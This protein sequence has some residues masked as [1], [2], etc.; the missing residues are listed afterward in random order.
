MRP[1]PTA[2]KSP[3]KKSAKSVTKKPATAKKAAPPPR[4]TK[5]GVAKKPIA[6]KPVVKKPV[7]KKPVPKKAGVA[8]PK[9]TRVAST[10]PA[11][12]ST[13]PALP[14][15]TKSAKTSTAKRSLLDRLAT[16]TIP[17]D[18]WALSRVQPGQG[19]TPHIDQLFAIG[20]PSM[21]TVVDEPLV[22]T[23]PDKALKTYDLSRV[24]SLEMLPRL[25]ALKSAYGEDEARLAFAREPASFQLAEVLEDELVAGAWDR[26]W[27]LEAMFGATS[28][29]EAFVTA[30]TLVPD[31]EWLDGPIES[32]SASVIRGLGAVLDRTPADVRTRLRAQLEALYTRLGDAA[33]GRPGKALDVILHGRAGVERSGNRTGNRDDGPIH[34][35][36]LHWATDDPAWVVAQLASRFATLQPADREIF[37]ARHGVI[38]GPDAVAAMRLSISR[39]MR[40]HRHA[41]TEQLALFA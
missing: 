27:M 40:D 19:V 22:S 12:A 38:G 28:V 13:K 15:K 11:K 1:M 7:V 35:S 10:T 23:D 5:K 6:K 18:A 4:P 37:D 30:F 16:A 29:A 34:L 24:V 2:K 31:E 25:Y 21:I 17:A 9:P 36:E 14:S 3:A 39:L 41:V 20:F 32:G 26:I 33:Q 8:R